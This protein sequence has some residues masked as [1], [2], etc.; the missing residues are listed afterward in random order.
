MHDKISRLSKDCLIH[1]I[2]QSDYLTRTKDLQGASKA[3]KRTRAKRTRRDLDVIGY[4][5]QAKVNYK[6]DA[7]FTAPSF[8]FMDD[9]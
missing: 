9:T 6:L 8:I 3:K 5:I 7:T 1:A 4:K 2:S